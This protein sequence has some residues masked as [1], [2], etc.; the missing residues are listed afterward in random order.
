VRKHAREIAKET[1]LETIIIDGPPGTG[2]PVISSV[3][4]ARKAIIVTEPSR[5][6]FHDMKRILEL[7]EGFK[8]K[9]YVVINKYDLNID[10]TCQIADWCSDRK[11]PVAGKI[12]FD[13]NIVEA[14][15]NCKSIIEWQPHSVVSKEIIIIW[16]KVN[17]DE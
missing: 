2:C 11:I 1:G 9:S 16:N 8:V 7:T 5:S 3:T 14:M 13:P 10:I 17:Q 4:G 12:P 15:L 6:G